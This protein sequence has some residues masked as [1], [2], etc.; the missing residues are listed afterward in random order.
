M[1]GGTRMP[2]DDQEPL[3]EIAVGRL[4]NI[5]VRE[6]AIRF[7]FGAAAS[8][9][10]GCTTLIFGPR[11]GGLFLAF[12]AI[13]AASLTLIE[14]KEGN[15]AAVHDI[16]GAV[17]GAVGLAAFALAFEAALRTTALGFALALGFGTWIATSVG[18]YLT[19]ELIRRSTSR[20]R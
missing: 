8:L 5:D 11:V 16:K 12:P 17:L 19:I 13:L 1:S 20:R 6:V 15:R 9:L 7:V 18:L 4:G 2:T 3:A 14:K 10:A